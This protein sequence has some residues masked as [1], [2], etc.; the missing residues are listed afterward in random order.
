MAASMFNVFV[1]SETGFLK[2]IN[3]VKDYWKN[4][5]DVEKPSK[6][7]EIRSLSWY[8]D[9]NTEM[10]VGL[11]NQCLCKFDTDSQS[12]STPVLYES[13]PGNLRQVFQTNRL[14]V[15]ALDSGIVSVWEGKD[16]LHTIQTVQKM[17]GTL[18]CMQQNPF[19]KQTIA[20]GGK[21]ADFKLWD[22]NQPE[23]PLFQAKNVKNDWLNLE[24]P[25]WVTGIGFLSDKKMVTSTGIMIDTDLSC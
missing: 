1:G 9:S 24:V 3:V 22:L 2:G 13:G 6:S 19:D 7:N 21:Q 12:I 15:T 5:N 4:L 17:A 20:T 25:V 8:D 11:R 23:K 16:V 14:T 18:H 10:C